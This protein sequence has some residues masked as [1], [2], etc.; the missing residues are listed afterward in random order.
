MDMQ[1]SVP[2]GPGAILTYLVVRH[3]RSPVLIIN[4]SRRPSIWTEAWQQKV[5]DELVAHIKGQFDRTPYDTI[6]GLAGIGFH[7]K[8]CKVS[9]SGGQP[10]TV[11]DWQDNVASGASLRAQRAIID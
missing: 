2:A 3:V 10:T 8:V 6:Y 5:M 1:A 11:V 9:R 4:L 7:W